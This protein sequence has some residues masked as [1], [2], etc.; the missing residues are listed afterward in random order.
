MA[1]VGADPRTIHKPATLADSLVYALRERYGWTCENKEGV[2]EMTALREGVLVK[3]RIPV[4]EKQI[5]ATGVGEWMNA[6]CSALE[7]ILVPG[8]AR[9]TKR[10]TYG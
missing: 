1:F 9:K 10:V 2:V 4:D 6:L 7:S 8:G 3:V 5:R